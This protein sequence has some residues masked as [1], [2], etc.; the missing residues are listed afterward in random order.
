M[1]ATETARR[2]TA[3][4]DRATA[5][6]PLYSVRDVAEL[7][8]CSRQHVY[9]LIARRELRTEDIGISRS[10]TRVPASALIEF[11]NRHPRRCFPAAH[12]ASRS[13]AAPQSPP[14][15]D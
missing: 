6:E 10:K 1:A 2:R 7:W 13:S 3:A 9:N 4:T 11:K 15:G 8:G 12:P 14:P 5:V